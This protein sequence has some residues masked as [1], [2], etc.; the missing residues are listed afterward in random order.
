M[1]MLNIEKATLGYDANN[2]QKLLNIINSDVIDKTQQALRDNVKLLR[3]A[4]DEVWVGHSAI[5]FKNNID[6]DV[7]NVCD[8]LAATFEVLKKQLNDIVIEMDD[9]DRNLVA[10]R[11]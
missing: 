6:S 8:A 10:R 4:T 9:D 1:A 2:I 11:N 7:K 3:D 5:Q